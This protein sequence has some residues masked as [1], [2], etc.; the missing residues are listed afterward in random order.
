[1][2]AHGLRKRRRDIGLSEVF[3][4]L[5]RKWGPQHWWPGRTRLEI[6]VGA[7]LTQNTAWTNV[8]KAIR[9]LRKERA[10]SLER[11]RSA[12]LPVLAEWIRPAGYYRVKARRLKALMEAISASSGTVRKF[13]SQDTAT[14][15]AALLSVPGVGPETADSILLYAGQ[16]PVFVVDA[17]TRRMLVRHGW[18]EPRA[19]YDEIASLFVRELPRS[20]RVYNE[21]HALI[22]RL[23]KTHCRA[24]PLCAGCPLERWLPK[25]G[26][27]L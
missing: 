14:L 19:T 7:V 23:G 12:P 13:F 22:V 2:G 8:E 16:R 17:Y 3:A 18:I 24:K 1:M 21:F 26:P 10:L 11:L 5:F 20:V 6:M 9:R 27:Y 25:R 4:A 15:R